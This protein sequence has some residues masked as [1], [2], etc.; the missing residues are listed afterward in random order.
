MPGA[1]LRGGE[2]VAKPFD[3]ARVV[4]RRSDDDAIILVVLSCSGPAE[5]CGDSRAL[6]DHVLRHHLIEIAGGRYQTQ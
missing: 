5:R 3:Q 6:T 1:F 2:D 4:A